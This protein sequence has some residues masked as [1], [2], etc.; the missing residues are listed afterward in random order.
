MSNIG[1]FNPEWG[2]LAPKPGFIRSTRVALATGAMGI[3]AG[4]AVA[5][6]LVAQPT[7]DVSVAARTMAPA[8]ALEA[9]PTLR[10]S[11]GNAELAESE[12]QHVTAPQVAA[13]ATDNSRDAKNFAAAESPSAVTAQQPAG[14]SALAE[15]P[16]VNDIAADKPSGSTPLS[17]PRKVSKVQQPAN[18]AALAEARGLRNDAS[19]MS[20]E[21]TPTP[22]AKRSN[23]KVQVAPNRTARDDP[24]SRERENGRPFDFFSLIGR[25]I[26]GANSSF[27]DQIR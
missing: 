1:N 7:A 18:V 2:Y 8:V 11:A 3:V 27:N 26:L 5:V 4:M 9:S 24:N 14:V 21:A 17:S 15:A 25:T 13:R 20:S 16:A 23:R 6:A 12:T 22:A 19:E 10:V